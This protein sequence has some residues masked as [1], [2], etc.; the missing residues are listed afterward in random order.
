M[1]RQD[2]DIEYQSVIL[3]QSNKNV[4]GRLMITGNKI[5]FQKKVGLISK[6]YET[7]FQT[8]IESI[9]KIEKEG[10]SKILI[11][12]KE[13]NITVKFI[14]DTP[15]EANEIS[16]KINNTINQLIL[17]T[18][19]KK[20]D[21]I[22]QRINLANYSTYVYDITL[23]LWTAISLLFIIMRETID[24]NWDEV[25]RKVEDFKEIVAEL[26]NNKVNINGEAKNIITSIKS[27]DDL[28]IVNSIR[29]LIKTLGE[30]LQGP[31]PYSEWREISSVMKPSWEN[32][33]FFYLFTVAVFESYY[34]ENMNMDEEKKSS[35]ANVIKYIPIVNGHFSDQLFD[36]TKYSTKTL[37]ERNDTIEQLIDETTDKLQELLKD[38]L[39]KASLLN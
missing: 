20:K 7:E 1:K 3:E 30:S 35:K 37:R 2:K 32:L 27:R 18:E 36:K 34:F 31:V 6:K 24:N 5:L 8:I 26:E 19:E 29:V 25:D 28:T 17:D 9:N 10:Y 39:K 21:E 38:S 15:V 22:D 13:K 14:L 23:E 33:Q 4:K 16:D 11:T 12:D